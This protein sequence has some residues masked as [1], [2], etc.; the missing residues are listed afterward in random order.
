M[1]PNSWKDT[2]PL[3]PSATDMLSLESDI[4]LQLWLCL[5]AKS[6]PPGKTGPMHSTS[7]LRDSIANS[8][9]GLDILKHII[10]PRNEAS[11]MRF[12]SD[13]GGKQML[14]PTIWARL[15]PRNSFSPRLENLGTKTSPATAVPGIIAADPQSN[16]GRLLVMDVSMP[17]NKEPNDTDFLDANENKKKQDAAFPRYGTSDTT[18]IRAPNTQA[19]EASPDHLRLQRSCQTAR[20]NRRRRPG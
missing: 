12:L 20:Q 5:P 10:R 18:R 13:L 3:T 6:R 15:T 4:G 1:G 16:Y 17:R 14:V 8:R 7:R 2:L 11:Y 19:P 9:T